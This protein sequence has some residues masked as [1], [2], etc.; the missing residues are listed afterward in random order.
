M[1]EHEILDQWRHQHHHH[2]S[3]LTVR[4]ERNTWRVIALTAAMMVIEIAAGSILG[5]M[6][7]LADGWHMASHASAL[8]IS[9]FAYAYAR[10]HARNARYSF[11]T[12][13]VGV[14]GGFSSALVLGVIAVLIAWESIGRL[15]EPLAI[16]FDEAILVAVIGLVVNLVS[17]WMLDVPHED[18]DE[19]RHE[20]AHAH[21]DHNLRAAYLHVVADA[22]TS[23]FAIVALLAGKYLGWVWMDPVMG[24]VGAFVIAR[25]SFGLLRDTARVLLDGDVEPELADR[26]RTCIERHADN[27]VVDLHLWRVGPQ[28]LYG[29]ISLVTHDPRPPAHYRSL[30]DELA[31]LSHVTV[32]VNRCPGETCAPA[33]A[34]S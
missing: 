30:L 19:H 4:A 29:I 9:A 15:R 28:Q 24:V 16:G 17:A 22:L 14:L 2:L 8:G 12:W 21:H 23:V 33:P 6:A 26:L 13:K 1:H 7:L 34:P 27:R 10:R 32:E 25:W 11:G 3:D 20:H 18:H 31:D 5:S